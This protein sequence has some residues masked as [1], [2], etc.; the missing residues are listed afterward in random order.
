MAEILKGA[1]AAAA[2]NEKTAA[3]IAELKEKGIVPGLAILRVGENEA[4]ES[5]IRGIMKRAETLGVSAKVYALEENSTQEQVLECID[6]LNGDANV[7]GVL[8]MRPLPKHMDEDTVR[9]ALKPEKDLDGITDVALGGVFSGNNIGYA[10]CTAQ[11]C[12]EI[13]DHYGI[14]LKGKKV[15]VIGRSLVIGKPVAMMALGKNATVTICHSRTENLPETVKNADVVIAAVGKAGFVTGDMLKE[16][17]VVIDVGIN[18]NA[19]GK[20]CGD[21]DF[22][23]AEGIVNAITP[24]P[25]GVGSVTTAVLMNHLVNAA[26][27]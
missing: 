24:V 3:I 9:R 15:C 5:Y 18:V 13:L 2:I 23:A 10:P 21:V 22:D 16:G 20:L 4:D 7:H 17:Q 1:P 6:S 11:S 8:M 14:D 27:K 19:E 12:I 25:G 26:S